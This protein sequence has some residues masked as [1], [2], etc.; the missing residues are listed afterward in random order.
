MYVS[1]FLALFWAKNLGH[2]KF[3][4]FLWERSNQNRETYYS[5]CVFHIVLESRHRG[6]STQ[7]MCDDDDTFDVAG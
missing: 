1:K 4:T 2:A 7:Y 5:A 6:F 3:D